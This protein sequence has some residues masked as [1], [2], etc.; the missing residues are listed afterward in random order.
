MDL[1]E[2]MKYERV[3]QR[4]MGEEVGLSQSHISRWLKGERTIHVKLRRQ[5]IGRWPWLRRYLPKVRHGWQG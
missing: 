1:S 2:K 5:L 4:M 3:S